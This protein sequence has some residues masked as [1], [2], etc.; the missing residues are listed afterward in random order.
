MRHWLAVRVLLLAFRL[1]RLSNWIIGERA[2]GLSVMYRDWL[3]TIGG[4]GEVRFQS[5]DGKP[6]REPT[7]Q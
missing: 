3:F 6:I 7:N 2:Y 1:V 5:H 4:D